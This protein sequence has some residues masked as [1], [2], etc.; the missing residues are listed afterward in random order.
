MST[1]WNGDFFS[2]KIYVLQPFA[3]PGHIIIIII[4]IITIIIIIIIIII[5]WVVHV[6]KEMEGSVACIR[7]RQPAR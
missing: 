6:I 4:I 5:E 7:A 1:T 2:E 3:L